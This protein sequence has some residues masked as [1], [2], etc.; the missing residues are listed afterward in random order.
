MNKCMQTIGRYLPIRFSKPIDDYIKRNLLHKKLFLIVLILVATTTNAWVY[1]EHRQIALIAI[2]NLSPQNRE[3]LDKLWSEAR[4]GYEARL[5]GSVIDASQG[6]KPTKLDYAAWFAISGDHSCSP[7]NLLYNVLQTDWILNVAD[8]AAQL[9]IGIENSKT[10]I[11][12]INVLRS[13][14]IDFQKAD[15]EY[16]TRAGSNNIHFLLARPEV[17]TDATKYLAACLA[18]GAELNAL[19]A[20]AWFHTSAMLKA[21]RYAEKNL[22]A[23]EKSALILAALA[24]EAF[25][26]HFLQDAYAAGHIAGTWG[27][28][29]VRKGTHDY[30]NEKGLEVV[31]WDGKRTVVKGDAYMRPQ[32]A[33]F[34]AVTIR[35]SLEQLLNVASGKIQIN[36]VGGTASLVNLPD[37]FNVCKNTVVPYIEDAMLSLKAN[38]KYI[39]DVLVMTPVPG[40]ATGDGELPRFRSELGKF[41]GFSSALNGSLISGGFGKYQ[42][43][44][45]FVAGVDANI[46]FGFGLDGVLN[47]AAD[48]LVYIQVG[49]KLNGSS[50]NDFTNNDHTA[51][52]PGS[53]TSAIPGRTAYIIRIR[54]PFYLIPGDLLLAGPVLLL[55]SPKALTKMGVVAANGG[56]L[57]WQKGISTRFGRFA[58]VLGR[59]VGISFYG[60]NATKDDLIIPTS[61]ST[62]TLLQYRSTQFS[63]PIIEYRPFRTFSLDQ[64]SGLTVEL[65]A[66]FDVP[67]PIKTLIPGD[68]I[69]PLKYVWQAGVRIVFNWRHYIR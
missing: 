2:Q 29:S 67:H 4:K 34:A 51:P 39:V 28:A 1:P 63:F 24:E 36:R 19:G 11:Q 3:L 42:T 23:D 53:I 12:H 26:L 18:S 13:S 49:W 40:L 7:Q 44:S 54:A 59:E 61:D 37:S 6:R 50:T 60:L 20:Y 35:L 43:Q 65:N 32:D 52:R 69:P 55:A 48:G 45:G 27:D 41:I 33:E 25:A 14:D 5:T 62:T 38:Y 22:T 58:F 64:S 57:G 16:A 15:P 47:Q 9:N 17:S 10:P 66:G 31:T 46:R 8:V 21:G 56:L 30:Y 68:P